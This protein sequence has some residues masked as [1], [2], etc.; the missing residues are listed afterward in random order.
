MNKKSILAVLLL[1]VLLPLQDVFGQGMK[2]GMSRED[3]LSAF[4]QPSEE[5]CHDSEAGQIRMLFYG[6]NYFSFTSDR[7]MKMDIVS[8]GIV[9]SFSSVG[10]AGIAVGGRFSEITRNADC[11]FER[12]NS[13]SDTDVYGSIIELNDRVS[14]Q[15]KVRNDI[16]I[17]YI[18]EKITFEDS[19]YREFRVFFES[20]FNPADKVPGNS[21]WPAGIKPRWKL[22]DCMV[23]KDK[24]SL[25]CCV[26]FTA[27]YDVSARYSGKECSAVGR[28]LVIT[29]SLDGS[30]SFKQSVVSIVPRAGLSVGDAFT[31]LV[32]Y[33]N[34][35][36][37]TSF[38]WEY[39][40]GGRL[41]YSKFPSQKTPGAVSSAKVGIR[42]AQK[43][44]YVG[45]ENVISDS[46]WAIL[47]ANRNDVTSEYLQSSGSGR[48]VESVVAEKQKYS[49]FNV[50][51][52]HYLEVEEQEKSE[53][54]DQMRKEEEVI[55]PERQEEIDQDVPD[56][57]GVS[58]IDT[59]PL[60]SY[61][62]KTDNLSAIL[63]LKRSP[64]TL[65]WETREDKIKAKSV[66]GVVGSA[67]AVLV[68]TNIDHCPYTLKIEDGRLFMVDSGKK[69]VDNGHFT[70][71]HRYSYYSYK[72]K[73]IS[74]VDYTF[75]Y[76]LPVEPG[77]KVTL[78]PDEREKHRSFAVMMN[79]GDPVYAMR[80]GIVCLTDDERSVLVYHKDGTFAAYMNV[81]EACVY[82][83]EYVH[84]GDRIGVC[85]G[86]KLSVSIFYLDANKLSVASGYA[87]TH[88]TPY[89][90]TVDG[91]VKLQTGVEYISVVDADIVTKEMGAL[92]KKRYLKE[93]AK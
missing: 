56:S 18:I 60:P 72:G 15:M 37:G 63:R 85:G 47:A 7:L 61:F 21:L 41:V 44:S 89:I 43:L 23:S 88:L 62:G 1:V 9:L 3:F 59:M 32:V 19:V 49:F 54:S 34:V 40:E 57:L 52:P 68:C 70:M 48:S 2:L 77:T 81:D 6:E 36:T 76:A 27:Q 20:V 75:P 26:P 17:E 69:D 24:G 46:D 74:K 82:A 11:Q 31:G 65:A 22:V 35:N 25:T 93:N 64:L 84:P 90:R 4:G 91:D 39:Y 16:I 28:R 30:S 51:N 13:Y 5:I 80:G 78:I 83:G 10:L 8:E 58:P 79:V 50:P 86:G 33:D 92:K 42:L 73:A 12:V 66:N 67:K 87:Y 14:I 71:N 53:D 45:G 38:A 55:E 29:K